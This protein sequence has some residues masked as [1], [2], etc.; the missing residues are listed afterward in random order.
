MILDFLNTVPSGY[1]PT[2][3]NNVITTFLTAGQSNMDGR[4]LLSVAPE[5]L[6]QDNP[7]IEK[8]KMWNVDNNQ[9]DTYKIGVNTGANVNSSAYWGVDM[10]FYKLYSDY[11]NHFMCTIK[12]TSGGTAIYNASNE[13][14][15]WNTDFANIPVGTPI[16]LQELESR[17]NDAKLYAESFGKTLSVKAIIWFQGSS[18]VAIGSDAIIAY[19]ENF[20]SVIN[21]IR[22]TIVGN[23]LVPFI[24]GLQSHNSSQYNVPIME[25]GQLEL[26]NEMSNL[27]LVDSRYL[28]MQPDLLHFDADSTTW[29]GTE[30][31]NVLKDVI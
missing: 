17:Y 28:T 25:T 2:I 16:L 11:I 14:G 4:N 27:Y 23:P 6:D 22:N 24:F 7:I 9:F 20:R 8:L 31:Y 12:R 30:V 5:W 10:S 15:C 29:Y 18:D 1:T 26:L 21:Y 3:P 19:K 13:K